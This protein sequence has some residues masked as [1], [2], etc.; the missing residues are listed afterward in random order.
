MAI[1]VMTWVWNHS[2][3]RHGAR[4]VLL[5]V[6][7]S[8]SSDGGNAF[9]SVAE[10]MRKSNLGERAVQTAI[11]D[12]VALGELHVDRN[13]GPKGCNRYR[14]VMTGAPAESAPRKIH[15]PAESAPPQTLRGPD[16]DSESS[17]QAAEP[18]P[19]ESAPPQNL[20]PPAENAGGPAESAPVTV[21]KVKP[22]NS[23]AESSPPNPPAAKPKRERGTRIPGDF[24]VT[25]A[26]V[27]WARKECPLLVAAGLAKRETDKFID[28][29]HQAS[30]VNAVK[31]DWPAAWRNWMRRAEDDLAAAPR[32]APPRPAQLPGESTGTVRA[33]AASEAGK[34]VQ[35]LLD[36]GRLLP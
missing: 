13:G 34:R 12:L 17:P 25:D 1:N 7:D 6:A 14:V 36:E 23:P 24:A 16:E 35:A 3:S 15:T 29:W 27:Q 18:T 4:L 21:L 9:P 11:A 30:G 20:H 8:A 22:E 31:R 28:H 32:N 10:L 33:R 19:A 26:M 5:A 2:R